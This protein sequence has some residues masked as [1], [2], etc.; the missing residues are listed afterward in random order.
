MSARA[1]ALS[2]VDTD[3]LLVNGLIAAFKEGS[4]QR[5]LV[6]TKINWKALKRS[7]TLTM[8]NSYKT[9]CKKIRL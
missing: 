2:G 5:N 4:T 6:I 3:T 7:V 9:F 8:S 1:V